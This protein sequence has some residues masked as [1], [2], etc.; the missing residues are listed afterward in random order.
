[1]LGWYQASKAASKQVW[2]SYVGRQLLE[3]VI[4][5]KSIN[6]KG[7]IDIDNSHYHTTTRPLSL[8]ASLSMS[9]SVLS[10]VRESDN[11]NRDKVRR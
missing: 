1:M 10:G 8:S 6:E 5:D 7:Y 3:V 4:S 11:Y 9:S 2:E